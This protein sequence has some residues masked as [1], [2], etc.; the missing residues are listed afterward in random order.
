MISKNKLGV[1]IGSA[2]GLWHLAWVLLV[3]FGIAQWLLDWVFR[4]HF[5]QPVYVVTAFKLPFAV[6][7][8]AITS[9]LGYLFG[10]VAAAIWNDL[11]TGKMTTA[12]P[13]VRHAA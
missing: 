5:I 7:L 8:I 3:A 6:A 10:W 12:V 9:A 11:H 4:L 13:V 2:F 1:V